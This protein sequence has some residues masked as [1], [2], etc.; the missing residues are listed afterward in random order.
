MKSILHKGDGYSMPTEGAVVEGKMQILLDTSFLPCSCCTLVVHGF[1]PACIHP[2]AH[3][4]GTCE[5]RTFE[6]RDVTF[7]Y[8][9]GVYKSELKIISHVAVHVGLVTS[10]VVAYE[11]HV[12]EFEKRGNFHT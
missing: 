2:V 8:G 12:V 7:D 3:I 11:L 4:R 6:E 1:T 9:E 5:G 10:F